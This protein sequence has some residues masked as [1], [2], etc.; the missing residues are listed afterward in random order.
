MEVDICDE[1]NMDLLLNLR[2]GFCSCGIGNSAADQFAARLFQLV[3]LF[4]GGLHVSGV[5]LG[6]GLDCNVRSAAYLNAAH[7]D[8]L[9]YST[10]THLALS[11]T[12]S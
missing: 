10:I 5:G 1:R 3:N 8:R 2:H 6:H 7:I 12:L 9:S 11:P 4:D